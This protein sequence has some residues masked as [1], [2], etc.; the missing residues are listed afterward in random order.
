M[1]TPVR[2]QWYAFFL[3]AFQHIA[4]KQGD[5][6]V[7]IFA[8]S[9]KFNFPM[10]GADAGVVHGDHIFILFFWLIFWGIGWKVQSGKNKVRKGSD[11]SPKG[12]RGASGREILTEVLL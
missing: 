3:M 5:V 11:K 2:G 12:G 7:G 6:D 9:D 1:G 4:S 10:G 8:G